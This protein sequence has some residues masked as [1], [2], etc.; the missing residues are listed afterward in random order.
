[1]CPPMPFA[2]F[3]IQPSKMGKVDVMY[4][5]RLRDNFFMCVCAHVSKEII[6][7]T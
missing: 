4:V 6:S 7:V 2:S 5:H 1:M 3:G